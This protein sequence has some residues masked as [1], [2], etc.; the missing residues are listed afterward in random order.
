MNRILGLSLFIGFLLCRFASVA[1]A[2]GKLR[3]I[4]QLPLRD[5][6]PIVVVSRE[7]GDKTFDGKSRVLG[8]RDWLKQLTF[9]VKNVSN[10]NI[11][12]FN[13]DLVIPKQGQMQALIP[14]A[15]FFGNRI[16]PAI[17]VPGALILRPGE[18]VK[19]GVSAN[20]IALW[21]KVL[22][23]YEVEDFD[24]VTLD[25]REVHFDDGTGWK[26]GI[27]LQQDPNNPKIWRS[28]L[29]GSKSISG[30][31]LWIAMLAPAPL[32]TLFGGSVRFPFSPSE[33]DCSSPS[34]VVL[35]PPTPPECGYFRN[36][37]DWNNSCIGCTDPDDYIGCERQSPDVIYPSAPGDF[38]Y[39]ADSYATCR[40]NAGFPGGPPTCNSCPGFVRARFNSDSQCGQPGTCNQ[41]A[42]W[43]CATGFVDIAGIC[44]RSLAF[45]QRCAEPAGYDELTCTCPDGTVGGS[46]I[47]IDVDNSGFP[48]TNA[49][50]GVDFDLFAWGFP[51]RLAWTAPGSTNAF[52]VLDRNGNGTIDN[53]EELFGDITPQ[54]ESSEP[55]GF[56]ALAEYDKAENGGNSNGKI[57]HQDAIFSQLRLWQ[58]TN[59]NGISEPSEMRALPDFGL[60]TLDLDYR[61]SRR[62]D[63]HGNRFKYRAKVRDAQGAQ[64]GRWA[65]DVFFVMS[66]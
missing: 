33:V 15:I 66:P 26:L 5:D 31:S 2:Q 64:L 62:T 40:G 41:Q 38:G 48:L 16:A 19:V 1:D 36:D 25:I 54:P 6:S 4:Q 65:W 7:L 43:G 42:W 56:L 28:L 59:H 13:I 32:L 51:Q 44:Q 30:S 27:P 45:Q 37:T 20:E 63:E 58:D 11:V 14:V 52:L 55:N 8:D 49:A 53:G 47:L 39:I 17:A 46:P 3:T 10:K 35:S 61:E 57:N 22:K 18:I 50:N 60:R 9:G 34:E 12:Y 24:L 21:D 23:K 29:I